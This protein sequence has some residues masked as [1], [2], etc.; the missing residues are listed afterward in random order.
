M[1]GSPLTVERIR[2]GL[3]GDDSPRVFLDG[4]R[5]DDTYVLQ[6]RRAGRLVFYLSM[7]ANATSVST[8][9]RMRRVGACWPGSRGE[10]DEPGG[11]R[12]CRGTRGAALHPQHVVCDRCIAGDHE[13]TSPSDASAL[14]R[15]GAI[16]DV[17][18][19]SST[20]ALIN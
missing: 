16:D 18:M 2:S 19:A 14:D 7:V 3:A 9:Q 20:V 15:V 1:S 13:V 6:H 12:A 17:E 11:V 5:E 10:C 8:I 4:E